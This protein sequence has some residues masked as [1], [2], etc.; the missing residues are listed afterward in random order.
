MKYTVSSILF[1]LVIR[2]ISAASVF[3]FDE[4]PAAYANDRQVRCSFTA[5][6]VQGT[7]LEQGTL[8]VAIP[9][10]QTASQWL[11]RLAASESASLTN[12][13]LGNQLLRFELGPLPPYGS[14]VITLTADLKLVAVPQ[15]VSNA[16]LAIYQTPSIGIESQAP[17]ITVLAGRLKGP[18]PRATAR[19][20]FDWVVGNIA[21]SGF[22]RPN[23]GALWTMRTRQG[24][25]TEFA[26]LFVALCRANGVPARLVSGF[27]CP[28][29]LIL[30][31]YSVHDWAEFYDGQTWKLADPE[32]KNF[33][34]NA[35]AYIAFSVL[36]RLPDKT[37][38]IAMFR[39]EGQGLVVRMN[40]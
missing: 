21:Y 15:S 33:E 24:D 29:N 7:P 30:K 37:E 22:N 20:T 28:K 35:G 2:S 12:D 1:L 10:R 3:N 9:V 19:K 39:F 36:E 38:P 27:V 31:P 6:N 14:K 34:R 13:A 40:K 16:P 4:A 11:L 23:R 5:D 25:C 26:A 32:Q 17:E 18:T 8:W